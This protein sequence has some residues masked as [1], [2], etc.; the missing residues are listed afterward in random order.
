MSD[1]NQIIL[2]E[3]EKE[4]YKDGLR[5]FLMEE[6]TNNTCYP[7]KENIFAAFR[8]TPLNKVKVVILGQDPYHEPGQAMGLS[9]SV[10]ATEK[11]PPSLK[12]IYKEL[13]SEFGKCPANGDLTFWAKQGVLLLNTILSV[14]K[15]EAKSHHGHGWESFVENIIKRINE[16]DRPI[17]FLLWGKDAQS[18]KKYLTNPKH[19][20]LTTSH[21]SPF[22]AN[23]GFLGCNHFIEANSFLLNNGITTINWVENDV[24]YSAPVEVTEEYDDN[25]YFADTNMMTYAEE[26]GQ[27]T[28]VESSIM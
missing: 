24:N 12:N 13:E 25:S 11:L 23:R 3:Q 17:V 21:P 10:P 15:G 20:V 2:Q 5:G 19:L 7:A 22:S 27:Y 28:F 8:N 16:E 4:Y 1:W 14:R 26:G 6:Y 9:F 18:F